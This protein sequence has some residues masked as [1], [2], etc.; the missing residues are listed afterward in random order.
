MHLKSRTAYLPSVRANGTPYGRVEGGMEDRL[1]K[2]TVATKSL[3]RRVRPCGNR[4][5]APELPIR[6]HFLVGK[7]HSS[8][9]IL[10][11]FSPRAQAK[12]T[13]RK[14]RLGVLR[15]CRPMQRVGGDRGWRR[16]RR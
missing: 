3:V 1:R 5:F 11:W 7:L 6:A 4:G 13:G 14:R 10:Y 16:R 8:H 12:Q 2:S 9:G 15:S